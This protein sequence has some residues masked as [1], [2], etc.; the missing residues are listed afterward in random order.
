MRTISIYISHAYM[1]DIGIISIIIP[2]LSKRIL[3]MILITLGLLWDSISSW[4][5]VSGPIISFGL[6]YGFITTFPIGPSQIS[7]MRALLIEGTVD[8]AVAISGSITGQLI[9]ALSMYYSPIHAALGKPHAITLLVVPY[10]LFYRFR[11]NEKLFNSKSLHP[12]NRLKNS[13]ILSL[14]LDGLIFQLL[15]PVILPS[16]ILTRLVN[17]FLFRYSNNISF[18]I[19]SFCGW[20]SGHILFIHLAK[21]LSFRIERDSPIGYT[22]SKSYINRTFSILIFSYCSFYLGGA[23]SPIFTKKRNDNFAYKNKKEIKKLPNEESP[24]FNKPWPVVLFDYRRWNRPLRYIEKNPLNHPGPVKTEV[25]QYFFDTYSSCGEQRISFT[26]LPS[27]SVFG[28]RIGEDGDFSNT[29]Y[30]SEDPYTKWIRTKQSR[31]ENLINELRDRIEAL[32]NGYTVR[33]VMEKRVKVSNSQGDSF[34]KMYDP[35]LNGPFRGRINK[36]RSPWIFNDSINFDLPYFTEVSTKNSTEGFRNDQIRDFISDHWRESGRK[37]FPLPWEPLSLDTVRSFISIT[38]SSENG[39]VEPISEQLYLLAKRMILNSKNCEIDMKDLSYTAFLNDREI[40]RKSSLETASNKEEIY[41][42]EIY[43]KDPL[44]DSL[45]IATYHRGVY[46]QILLEIVSCNKEIYTKYLLNIPGQ[47]DEINILP[48]SP[49]KWELILSSPTTEQALLF[50]HLGQKEWTVLRNIWRNLSPGNSTRTKSIPALYA[51]IL[52]HEPLEIIEIQKHVPR[53]SYSF[54]SNQYD[55]MSSISDL[56]PRKIRSIKM[57]DPDGI[58]RVVRRYSQESDFRRDLVK[59]SIRAQRRKIR[60]C[61]MVQPDVHSPFFLEIMEIPTS[62]RYS[63]DMSDSDIVD[64][65]QFVTN[66]IEKDSKSG[67]ASFGDRS[68]VDRFSVAN[69]LDFS[70]NQRIRGLILVTQSITRKHIILPSLIIAKNIGRMLLFQVPEWDEDWKEWGREIHI[71]CTYDG[72]EF[73]ETE[74]PDGWLKDGIQIK[75]LFPFR[76]RPWYGSELRSDKG[77]KSSSSYLTT[78]GFETGVPFGYPKKVSSF[79]EPIRKELKGRLIKP[80]LSGIGRTKKSGLRPEN[81]R[82]TENIGMNDQIPEK[83]PI[84]TG[85]VGSANYLPKVQDKF[86]YGTRTNMKDLDDWT[87]ITNDQIQ[88]IT[89]KSLVNLEIHT[90]LRK[91]NDQCSRSGLKRGLV[92]IWQIFI[93]FRKNSVRFLR[94]WPYFMKL[95]IEG[96]DRDLFLSIIRFIRLNIQFWIGSTGNIAVIYRRIF[97]PNNDISGTSE[98]K[99]PNYHSITKEIQN[100]QVGLNRGMISMSQAYVFHEIWQIRAT[101]KAYLKHLLQSRTSYPFIKK[102]IKEFLDMQGILDSEEPQDLKGNDWKEWLKGYDRYN[103]SSQIWSRIAPQRWRNGVSKQRTIENRDFLHFYEESRFIPYEQRT[104]YCISAVKPSLGQTRKL[105]KRCRYNLL[106]YSYTDSMKNSDIHKLP[107]R[108]NEQEEIISNNV[109][110]ESELFY[111]LD[112]GDITNCKGIPR[113]KRIYDILNL[114][115][116]EDRNK[117]GS[118]IGNYQEIDRKERDNS[119]I[120]NS[121]GMNRRRTD[122]SGSDLSLWLFSEL[123]GINNTYNTELM[124]IP[125]KSLLR[126]E[127]KKIFGSYKKKEDVRSNV[128]DQE[129]RKQQKKEDVRLYVQEQRENVRSDVQNEKRKDNRNDKHDKV[130]LISKDGKTAEAIIQSRWAESIKR[131]LKK[132][133]NTCSLI[134]GMK[135]P[136]KIAILYIRKGDLDLNLISHFLDRYVSRK[137]KNGIFIIEPLR[138]PR[139]LDDQFLMYKIISISLKLNNRFRKGIDVN[140]FDGPVQREGVIGYENETISSSLIFEEILLPR[141]RREFRILNRFN[142]ENDLNENAEFSKAKDVQNHEKLVGRDQHLGIDTTQMIKRFIWPSYRLEDSICMNRYWF[143]TNDGSRS[144]MLRI[145]MYPLN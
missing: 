98:G 4:I 30:S 34:P 95:F 99:I 111:I 62:P 81:K 144:A 85:P 51:K 36:L 123:V 48:T 101:N 117:L 133:I 84:G 56:R 79:W 32:G 38:E 46:I 29:S 126:E 40:Y 104:K 145:R 121:T 6:Y 49:I 116:N 136:E 143:N 44:K 9:V 37:N 89:R 18:V 63:S 54:K 132:N 119:G 57:I 125:R 122:R 2:S 77:E 138:L 58:Q 92:H 7:S 107:V 42:E 93:Q 91:R 139:V 114:K 17:L 137:V 43:A 128:R 55:F 72:I 39:K 70:L 82:S 11:T 59:G 16:P 10:I 64:R 83:L 118:N 86:G 27:V 61:K 68:K 35:F 129:D 31:K 5:E 142:L 12:V 141:R 20:L 102:T 13:R 1:G 103:L 87:T 28:E 96:M 25:S 88:Q 50:E 69:K 75:I 53:W 90:D 100:L 124:I 109:I 97:I 76:S 120:L 113:G 71:K 131:K 112:D 45:E 21:L 135:D 73:S 106:S 14:F 33:D 3:N 130:K 66:C 74:L 80:I 115:K 22:I 52:F 60:I 23:P 65:K 41:A 19:S 140:I 78:W 26:S 134:S 15:N 108:Q 8:G 94:K 105:D 127:H 24:W 67:R 47:I 110:R